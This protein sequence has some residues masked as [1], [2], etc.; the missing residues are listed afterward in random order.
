MGDRKQIARLAARQHGVFSVTQARM[1]GYDKSAVRRRC[2]RGEWS[3]ID[4]SVLG[5]T[6]A[7]TTWAQTLMAAV[8][9]RPSAIVGHA[10]A[11]FLL[12]LKGVRRGTPVIVVPKGSN[13]RSDIARVVESDQ[14]ELLATTRV[15]MFDV[16]TVPETVL[17][18]AA[19]LSPGHLEDVF[20]EALLA[21]RLDLDAMK[22]VLDREAGRRPRGIRLLRDLTKS[23]LPTAPTRGS[24]YLEA[25]LERLLLTASI[26]RWTR[27][28]PFALV[29][30]PARVDVYI[31]AWSVVIEADGRNWHLRR[32]DFE[33]DRR[34]DNELASRGVQ[35]LRYTYEM[36]TTEPEHCLHEIAEVGRVRSASGVA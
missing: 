12:G 35:V 13:P 20:D 25:V 8:L 6:T 18:L 28:H 5:V 33:N 4:H 10:S 21:G 32:T 9:S 26:P 7:P 16:T 34:R 3:R 31:P 15:D 24:T 22:N 23:R 27:E 30:K 14:Y 29:G 19:D 2:E 11:A 17:C 1:A 36:L